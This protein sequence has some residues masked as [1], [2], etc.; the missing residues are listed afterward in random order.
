MQYKFGAMSDV[1]KVRSNNED[2][3]KIGQNYAVV[4]DG[5]G[6]HNKGEVASKMA[7]DIISDFITAKKCGPV[8]AIEAANKEIF[9]K[10]SKAEFAGMGTTTVMCI[11][12]E[13]KALIAN[14]GDSRGY[15]F[16]NGELKQITKDHSLV[17][18]LIDDG[19]ITEE[20][21]EMRADKSVILRAV[22]A[23][24]DIK[25]DVFEND[26]FEGDIILLCTDGLT[27]CVGKDKIIKT[28]A[29]NISVQKKAEE[30]VKNA[31]ENGGFDNITAVLLEFR[32]V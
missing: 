25:V 22:G 21:A 18:K 14:V 7:V 10:S 16:R 31:N 15:L 12:E 23:D 20:E 8:Q 9:K 28:L 17:Q 1:G 13:D 5:M 6:G 30:L 32:K 11:I 27:N 4:A 3:Y 24:K 2:S 19:E 29:K 26:V